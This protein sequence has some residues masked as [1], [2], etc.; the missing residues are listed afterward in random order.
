MHCSKVLGVTVALIFGILSYTTKNESI[1]ML[2]NLIIVNGILCHSTQCEAFILWDIAFNAAVVV[3]INLTNKRK[4]KGFALTIAA[5]LIW[6]TNHFVFH[7]SV[8]HALGVQF[9]GAV[10]LG[11][12]DRCA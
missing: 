8:V 1:R 5:L 9:I 4:A 7:S 10:V 6:L 11:E 3:L 12:W 2:S